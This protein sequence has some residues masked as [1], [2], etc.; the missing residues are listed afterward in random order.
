MNEHFLR[1]NNYQQLNNNYS[2][3]RGQQLSTISQQFLI[4]DAKVL[5]IFGMCKK[6]PDQWI[7]SRG[8]LDIYVKNGNGMG[9]RR[10]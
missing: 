6:I 2:F 5:Q 3:F 8:D 9:K 7:F 1:V 10:S 4:S